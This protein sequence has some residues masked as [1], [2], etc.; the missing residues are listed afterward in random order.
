MLKFYWID[1]EFKGKIKP[2]SAVYVEIFIDNHTYY[3]Q[4]D[5]G[6]FASFFY[7][8]KLQKFKLFESEIQIAASKFFN[9]TSFT[10]FQKVLNPVIQFDNNFKKQIKFIISEENDGNIDVQSN[11][12]QVDSNL[13]GILGNN[14]FKDFNIVNIDYVNLCFTFDELPSKYSLIEKVSLNSFSN[15][16]LLDLKF[17]TN[18]FKAVFDTAASNLTIFSYR[19]LEQNISNFLLLECEREE[20]F[21]PETTLFINKISKPISLMIGNFALK[22]NDFYFFDK[23]FNDEVFRNYD[24]D[25]VIGNELFNNY[26][27]SIN[28][29]ANEFSLY[30]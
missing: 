6:S 28:Y 21:R 3:L 9:Y 26:C 7:L 22:L 24:F 4:V 16:V 11:L 12:K 13:I 20:I 2:K 30:Q 18:T 1:L 27:V 23:Q 17:E 5:T 19:F 8:N 10:G 14:F 15:I 25:C 29:S